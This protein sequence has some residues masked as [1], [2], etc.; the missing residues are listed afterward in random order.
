MRTNYAREY[1][2]AERRTEY[3]LY[4]PSRHSCSFLRQSVLHLSQSRNHIFQKN[5]WHKMLWA[6][7]CAA[8]L[9]PL[10]RWV[11]CLETIIYCI[12]GFS[13]ESAEHGDFSSCTISVWGSLGQQEWIVSDN[14]LQMEAISYRIRWQSISPNIQCSP[15]TKRREQGEKQV[16]K[17]EGNQEGDNDKGIPSFRSPLWRSL[18]AALSM[19]TSPLLGSSTAALL[20]LAL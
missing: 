10:D 8:A 5:T 1:G 14:L 11:Q 19:I 2:F 7:A 12:Y 3:K 20:L 16:H 18:F 17:G 4:F 13:R 6:T 9:R 15:P